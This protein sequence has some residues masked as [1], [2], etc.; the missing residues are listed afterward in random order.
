MKEKNTNE[1]CLERENH[2]F[3]VL[4]SFSQDHI[5]NQFFLL[6]KAVQ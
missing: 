5:S 6:R 2:H 3:E 1:V 4:S